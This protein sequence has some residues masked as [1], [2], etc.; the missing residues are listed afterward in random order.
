MAKYK[1]RPIE[2]EAFHIE[3][4][5]SEPGADWP[6]WLHKAWNTEAFQPGR[7]WNCDGHMWL[8]APEGDLEVL[9]N[10]WIVLEE[11][12]DLCLYS[13]D[14]FAKWFTTV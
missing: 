12:G 1:R 6:E 3:S 8:S 14:A 9:L 13:P 5:Y 4:R 11:S 10:D 2:V 7:F